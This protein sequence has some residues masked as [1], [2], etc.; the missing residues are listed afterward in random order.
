MTLSKQY[1]KDGFCAIYNPVFPA[2][3]VNAAVEGM[4]AVRAG[5]YDTGH[6]PEN[7]R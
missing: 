1:Q 6:P 7:S 4:D 2:A 3:A 5:N